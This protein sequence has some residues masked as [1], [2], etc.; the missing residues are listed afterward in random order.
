MGTENAYGLGFVLSEDRGGDG[1]D[2]ARFDSIE[3]ISRGFGELGS[4]DLA[5]LS[6]G[7]LDC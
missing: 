3:G 7:D 1:D 2:A 4:A 6:V 5:M